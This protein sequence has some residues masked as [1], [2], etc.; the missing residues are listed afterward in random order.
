MKNMGSFWK[1]GLHFDGNT[2]CAWL[3]PPRW[4]V[5]MLCDA[6]A[7]TQ[8]SMATLPLTLAALSHAVAREVRYLGVPPFA[9]YPFSHP[10]GK[11]SVSHWK[12]PSPSLW[13]AW[14]VTRMKCRDVGTNSCFACLCVHTCTYRWWSFL[15]A[16]SASAE[17]QRL[18]LHSC[19]RGESLWPDPESKDSVVSGTEVRGKDQRFPF[20]HSPF[21]SSAG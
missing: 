20:P 1:R 19:V 4:A 15:P 16:Q 17:E 12:E 10:Q 13:L 14:W 7:W 6:Q 9:P 21:C 5:L 3:S 2:Q 18:P 8:L 11:S